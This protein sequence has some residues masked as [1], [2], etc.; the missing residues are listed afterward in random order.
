MA[1]RDEEGLELLRN[2][3]VVLRV[4]DNEGDSKWELDLLATM[5][6]AHPTPLILNPES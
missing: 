2:A 5:V 4:S 1:G 3:L 6:E